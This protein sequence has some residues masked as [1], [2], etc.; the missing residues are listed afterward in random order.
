MHPSYT[1]DLT[2]PK[3]LSNDLDINPFDPRDVNILAHKNHLNNDMQDTVDPSQADITAADPVAR[4]ADSGD[5]MPTN[6]D[7]GSDVMAVKGRTTAADGEVDG[8]DQVMRVGGRDKTLPTGVATYDSVVMRNNAADIA[9]NDVAFNDDVPR[10]NF[11]YRK[12]KDDMTR[13]NVAYDVMSD[14]ENRQRA[15]DVPIQRHA[16]PMTLHRHGH[17]DKVTETAHD[18]TER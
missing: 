12:Y 1:A 5:A 9:H 11:A 2:Q 17:A 13:K 3:V 4:G 15:D 6:R 7:D 10:K 18:T 14:N 16:Q 8:G